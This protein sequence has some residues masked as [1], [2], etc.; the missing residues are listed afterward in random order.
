MSEVR[1]LS[2]VGALIEYESLSHAAE[3][4]A[5][6]SWFPSLSIKEYII[7]EDID[8]SIHTSGFRIEK[9]TPGSA[10]FFTTSSQFSMEVSLMKKA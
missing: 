5:K 9:N 3:I 4:K 6:A 2:L 7:F 1:G 10:T 8:S